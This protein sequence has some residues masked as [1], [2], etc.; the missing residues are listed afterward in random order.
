MKNTTSSLEL[1]KKDAELFISKE[2]IEYE[3][4]IAMSDLHMVRKTFAL[5]YETFRESVQKQD[6]ELWSLIDSSA[7]ELAK[8]HGAPFNPDQYAEGFSEGVAAVWE[9]IKDDIL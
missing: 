5:T 3:P 1:G 8:K 7:T 6:P 4:F 2:R 9:K